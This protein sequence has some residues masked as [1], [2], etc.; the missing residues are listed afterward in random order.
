MVSYIRAV[1][2]APTRTRLLGHAVVQHFWSLGVM[3]VG[4][5]AFLLPDWRD[6]QLATSAACI[7]LLV[8]MWLVPSPYSTIP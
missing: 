1:E 8:F 4:L 2:M 5:V 3:L 6:F 7:P